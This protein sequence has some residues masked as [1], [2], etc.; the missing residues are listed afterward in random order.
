MPHH[1][2]NQIK[3]VL[4]ETSHPGN[5]GAA[6]RAMKNM[7]LKHLVLV[8]PKYFPDYEAERR[9]SGANDLLENAQVVNT[10]EEAIAGCHFVVA[11]SARKRQFRIEQGDLR[12][13]AEKMVDY[14]RQGQTIAVLFGTE[15]TGLTN[16]Q[17]ERAHAFLTVPCNPDYS[18]LNVAATVQLVAYEYAMAVNKKPEPN[19]ASLPQPASAEQVEA[20]LNHWQQ[21]L[22][23]IDYL[24]PQC[25]KK[26]MRRLQRFFH[27]ARPTKEEINIWRGIANKIL[28]N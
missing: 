27:K 5:I 24:D 20:M 3:I 7:G 12:P 2:L 15:R 11:S 18:S 17:L 21:A 10:L 26:L 13:M 28:K 23:K 22:I 6:A 16:Q 8:K 14:A 19:N 1:L 4:V 9:A 25:P